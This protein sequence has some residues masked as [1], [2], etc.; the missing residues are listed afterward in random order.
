MKKAIR[1]IYAV[2]FFLLTVFFAA[3]AE[4]AYAVPAF[5]RQPGMA[6]NSCHFQH[7]PLLN[8]FGRSFKSDGYTTIGGQSLMEGDFL[9]LPSVLNASLVTKLRYQKTN[10]R[11]QTYDKK[12][13]GF[14]ELPNE[15]ALLL[16][17]RVGEHVGFLLEAQ[18]VD[19]EA[20]GGG[21]FTMP[22]VDDVRQ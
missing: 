22:I 11:S 1:M 21:S 7:F 20:P 10:G 12:N 15:G 5:G 17:G 9:S 2:S 14:L 18:L 6:C 16:G 4:N 13:R 3:S 8:E 19:D